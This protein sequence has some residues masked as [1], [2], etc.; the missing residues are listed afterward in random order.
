MLSL[1][2]VL[3]AMAA[4]W[5]SDGAFMQVSR[6]A[7]ARVPMP[8][9]RHGGLVGP[10][11]QDA[12]RTLPSSQRKG[13]VEEVS[14]KPLVSTL[15][16]LA[17][18]A[19]AAGVAAGRRSCS[20]PAGRCSPPRTQCRQG[21]PGIMVME[22][23]RTSSLAGLVAPPSLVQTPKGTYFSMV[24]D[25]AA[26]SKMSV[27]KTFI[28]SLFGGCYVGMAG[29]LSLVISG[30]MGAVSVSAQM[31]VF[32]ALFPASLLLSMQSGARI[33]TASVTTMAMAVLEGKATLRSL[34]R[35]GGITYV[36]NFVGCG[37]LALVSS[38]TG[39]LTAGTADLAVL[40]ALKKCG[41]HFGPLVLKATLGAW[42]ACMAV[43]LASQASDLTGKTVGIWFTLSM[44]FAIGFEHCVANMFLLPAA[45]LANAPLTVT[46]A[47][48]RNLFPV[49]LGSLIAVTILT[50][51]GLSF[52]HGKLG[53]GR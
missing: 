35:R 45:I 17:A 14:L 2:L 21:Q 20:G 19:T 40:I 7:L 46:E 32:A 11:A 22:R 48:V 13:G 44:S 26:D 10:Y 3:G 39:L 6:R 27:A 16:G 9:L 42:L 36:G 4:C 29:L 5:A 18:A 28:A 34:L 37:L 43:F 8:K 33:F 25:G 51:G 23:P 49:T 53:G 41:C 31:Y 15:G 12:R 30:N 50:A 47:L 24:E 38:Y 52:L 1:A